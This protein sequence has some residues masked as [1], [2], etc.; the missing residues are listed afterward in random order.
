M[1][2]WK[3]GDGQTWGRT[4]CVWQGRHLLVGWLA[5]QGPTKMSVCFGV[6]DLLLHHA[7]EDWGSEAPAS[8]QSCMA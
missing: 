3:H 6:G 1:G 5:H 7:A 2:Q 4:V 8:V